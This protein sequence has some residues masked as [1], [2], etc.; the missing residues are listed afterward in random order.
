M[1]WRIAVPIF[2]ST[3]KVGGLAAQRVLLYKVYP[4]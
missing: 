4:S 1:L 3:E 2:E